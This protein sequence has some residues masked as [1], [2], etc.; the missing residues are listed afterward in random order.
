MTEEKEQ[1]IFKVSGV[2]EISISELKK[3]FEQFITEDCEVIITKY[4]KPIAVLLGI[5]VYN[6]YQ[7]KLDALKEVQQTAKDILDE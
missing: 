6:K 3:N 1:P 4:G 2:K 7:N 5:N